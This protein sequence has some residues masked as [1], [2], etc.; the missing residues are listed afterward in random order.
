ME[1]SSSDSSNEKSNSRMVRWLL[2][3]PLWILLISIGIVFS[4]QWNLSTLEQHTLSLAQERGRYTFKIIETTRL[5]V[6]QHG[7]AYVASDERTPSNPYLEVPEKDISTPSGIK[8]TAVNP[9][10]MTRQ[11]A[12][13]LKEKHDLLV[14]LTSLN[15]LNPGNRADPWETRALTLFEKRDVEEIVEVIPENNT[16]Y[17]R[18]MAPLFVKNA[19][20]QCHEKQ[21]YKVGDVRGGISVS[22]DY[23]PFVNSTAKQKQNLQFIHVAIWATLSLFTIVTL[24]L[25][26]R[27][28]RTIEQSRDVAE[29]LV[30]QRTAELQQALDEIKTL[31]GII[32]ICSYCH[33][34]RSDEG[35]WERMESYITKHSDASFS[36]GICPDCVKAARK[37][38]GLDE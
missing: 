9:A 34:I 36:H 37:D 16:E 7:V 3:A 21:G 5:W 33:K 23:S 17:I 2:E 38:A 29:Q 35:A 4:Y 28:E 14:H 13:L 24:R 31:K 19:C 20:M 12:G 25:I 32:P 30:K 15:P 8:L 22:F 18:Y 26:K 1:D 10:Y 11:L 27:H 6:A